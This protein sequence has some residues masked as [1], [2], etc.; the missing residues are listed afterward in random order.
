MKKRLKILN[1]GWQ[2]Y[3]QKGNLV[4]LLGMKT[5]TAITEN[6]IKILQNVK[7]RTTLQGLTSLMVQWVRIYL[8]M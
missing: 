4:I 3:V 6:S 5:G 1:K 8:Q 7:R 2:E